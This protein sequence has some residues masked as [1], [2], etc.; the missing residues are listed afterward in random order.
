MEGILVQTILVH[1]I[2]FFNY[3][4]IKENGLLSSVFDIHHGIFLLS[5]DSCKGTPLPHIPCLPKL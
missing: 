3:P 4:K 1:K 5:A 2:V